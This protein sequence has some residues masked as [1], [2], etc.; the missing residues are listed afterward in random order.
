MRIEPMRPGDVPG[1]V[2]I[3]QATFPTPWSFSSFLFEISSNPFA[4]NLV[5]RNEEGG[6]EGYACAWIVD[7]EVRVNNLAV[8]EDRR[9]KGLGESLLRYLLD[10]GREQRC[11]RAVLDVRPSNHPALN[12]YKKLGF[13]PVGRRRGYYTD[14]GEDALVMEADL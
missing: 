3:E 7:R 13:H 14:S 8:R 12:L 4:C 1:V 11:T 5:V 9:R 6:V 2:A 10:L